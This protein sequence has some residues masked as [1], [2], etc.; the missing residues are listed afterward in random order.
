MGGLFLGHSLIIIKWTWVVFF[1]KICNLTSP[2]I[3]YKIVFI[4]VLVFIYDFFFCQCL[5]FCASSFVH[6]SASFLVWPFTLT[7]KSDCDITFTSK[8]NLMLSV[9]IVKSKNY[10]RW[11]RVMLLTLW[12]H[13]PCLLV[14]IFNVRKICILHHIGIMS[15]MPQ[16]S[17]TW[18]SCC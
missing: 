6:F 17:W 3:R 18:S 2:A 4:Y 7:E 11:F 16:C 15:I 14:C 12:Y 13:F 5:C 10:S 8:R 9:T 1:P